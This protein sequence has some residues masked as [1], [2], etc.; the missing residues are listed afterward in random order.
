MKSRNYL[1]AKVKRSGGTQTIPLSHVGRDRQAD[2]L[3]G[4]AKSKP[5]RGRL[6]LIALALLCCGTA[7]ADTIYTY[8]GQS[9]DGQ[10]LDAGQ[11]PEPSCNCSLNGTVDFAGTTAV[12]WN[13]TDGL[14]TLTQLNS[15]ATFLTPPTNQGWEVW[16][17][18]QNGD[19]FASMNDGAAGEESDAIYTAGAWTGYEE[20][21]PGVWSTPEPAN[22]ILLLLALVVLY[23]SSYFIGRRR[24]A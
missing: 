17:V 19:I 23:M 15:K 2:A 4:E 20:S 10:L 7:K 9:M 6:S 16:L 5:C 13:F 12:A 18:G 21:H 1:L 8:A 24:L 3:A 14:E 22:W 11:S